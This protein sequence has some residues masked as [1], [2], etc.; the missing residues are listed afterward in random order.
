VLEP[1]LIVPGAGGALELRPL[2]DFEHAT[3]ALALRGLPGLL[4]ALGERRCA[5]ALHVDLSVDDELFSAI[6]LSVASTIAV[7]SQYARV[8]RDPAGLPR[9]GPWTSAPEIED[10]L[11]ASVRRTLAGS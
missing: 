1:S 6:V 7:S 10:D 5:V 11:V 2:A 9:L 3:E 4:A 8:E